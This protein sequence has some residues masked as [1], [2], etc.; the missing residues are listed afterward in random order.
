MP[1]ED[2]VIAISYLGEICSFGKDSG[3]HR[4]VPIAKEKSPP[5]TYSG[6]FGFGVFPFHTDLAHWPHPPRYLALRCVVGF[7]DVST[8]LLDGDT[9]VACTGRHLLLN[10]LVQP[11]RPLHGKIP[12]Y[13]LLRPFDER[14]LIRWDEIFIRPANEGSSAVAK[15][16]KLAIGG[17]PPI[18]IALANLGDTLI[19]DNWRMLHSRTA[20]RSEHC[21]RKIDRAYLGDIY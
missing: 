6:M 11:R 3:V 12:L 10:S 5:N 9:V 1:E 16:F 13:R 14:D 4:V 17:E 21:M 19:I 7:E 15:K 2:P 8:L 20:I 18:Q